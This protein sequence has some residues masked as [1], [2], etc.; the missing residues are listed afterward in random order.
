[1][2]KLEEK[3]KWGAIDWQYMTE[4]SDDKDDTIHQ[5]HYPGAVH[6]SCIIFCIHHC[7]LSLIS[8]FPGSPL[9]T[10]ALP[11]NR[12]DMDW[13]HGCRKQSGGWQQGYLR[14][15]HLSLALIKLV[16]TSDK[17]MERA[18]VE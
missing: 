5:H 3:E 6:M 12:Y 13:V 1:M 10:S 9:H 7:T 18:S 15:F 11:L 2:K 17:Q 4:K 16:K 14:L 8:S